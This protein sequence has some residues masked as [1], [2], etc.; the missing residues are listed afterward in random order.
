MKRWRAFWFKKRV[1]MKCWRDFWRKMR[2]NMDRDA[3][4]DPKSTPTSTVDALIG[5]KK[6]INMKHWRVFWSK[7][8]VNV[9]RWRAFWTKK[10]VNISRWRAFRTKKCVNM[11]RWRGLWT[12]KRVN[13]N[14]WRVFLDDI[15]SG[16]CD[17]PPVCGLQNRGY[18]N[19]PPAPQLHALVVPLFSPPKSHSYSDSESYGPF[20]PPGWAPGRVP[21]GTTRTDKGRQ[22]DSIKCTCLGRV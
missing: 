13:V 12:K 14:R 19:R 10:R 11:M 9:N 18:Q 5:T 22:P 2:V 6:H 3:L 15:E 8:R 20:L 16:M 4:F 1:N 21:Q 7:K 17:L